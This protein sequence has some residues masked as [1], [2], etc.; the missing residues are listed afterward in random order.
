[1]VMKKIQLTFYTEELLS[2]IS[3]YCMASADAVATG[4][5]DVHNTKDVLDDGNREVV[6][7][8]ISRQLYECMHI[9]Y[10]FA[11]APIRSCY[12]DNDTKDVEAYVIELDFP[13]ER[14]ETD[15]RMLQENIQSYI[16]Y[17]CLSE[18]LALT[19]PETGQWQMWESKAQEQREMITTALVLP[20][21]PMAVRVRPQ[22]Y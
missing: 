7:R 19:L 5:R 4:G 17:K 10:P 15:V 11:K 1:M 2:D 14:N 8:I 6:Q 3:T 9:L 12:Y 20:L 18:W 22:F 13:Y 21:K 16:V